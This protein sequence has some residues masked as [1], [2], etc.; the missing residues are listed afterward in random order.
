MSINGF[1]EQAHH[2]L[3]RPAEN[4]WESAPPTPKRV[5]LVAGIAR[6]PSGRA[7]FE[8]IRASG[9]SVKI[10]RPEPTDPPNATVGWE[11]SAR[12]A[13]AEDPG[14][15]PDWY[16]G[17]D[18]QDWPSPFDPDARPAEVMLF[19]LLRETLARLRAGTDPN[20]QRAIAEPDPEEA[21]AIARFRQER[22][23]Q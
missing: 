5:P 20:A 15:K 1:A 3:Q 16:I 2:G 23:A 13:A 17:F 18:P 6:T 4:S 22:E 12:G 8:G 7:I 21:A 11:S 14:A 19:L 9:G 10:E